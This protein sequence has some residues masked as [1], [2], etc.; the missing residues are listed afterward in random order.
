MRGCKFRNVQIDMGR[1]QDRAIAAPVLRSLGGCHRVMLRGNH[2][3][4]TLNRASLLGEGKTGV[5]FPELLK[6]P[7]SQKVAELRASRPAV[8]KEQSD[9]LAKTAGE[10]F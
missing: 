9:I 6:V 8:L 5:Y 3:Q 7:C 4:V 2:I 1:L 10:T